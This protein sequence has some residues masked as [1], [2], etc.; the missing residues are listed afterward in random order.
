MLS[1]RRNLSSLKIREGLLEKVSL[2]DYTH[3]R[4]LEVR[5][6]RAFLLRSELMRQKSLKLTHKLLMV[7]SLESISLSM[8]LFSST[9]PTLISSCKR[10]VVSL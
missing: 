10:K 3:L 4:V 7:K 1:V 9:I 8:D 5:S 2:Q 6:F